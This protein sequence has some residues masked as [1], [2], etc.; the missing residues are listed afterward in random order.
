V[1]LLC[2]SQGIEE[3]LEEKKNI[4]PYCY[5][6]S[7]EP[8]EAKSRGAKCKVCISCLPFGLDGFRI[9]ILVFLCTPIQIVPLCTGL[10]QSSEGKAPRHV[11]PAVY[12][13]PFYSHSIKVISLLCSTMS[14]WTYPILSRGLGSSV[15][16]A[17][18]YGLEGPG[19][20]PGGDEIFRP[21]RPVLGHTQLPAKW[22]PGL[23][24]G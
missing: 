4:A 23:Y 1:A 7:P 22:V 8:F 24:R 3:V 17:T 15:G 2:N 21:S 5:V 14:G 9:N 12:K 19:L 11:L 18:D 20:N 13:V 10:I 16:I 6:Y